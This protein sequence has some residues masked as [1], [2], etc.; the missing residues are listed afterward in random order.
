MV[1]VANYYTVVRDFKTFLSGNSSN[2]KLLRFGSLKVFV[3]I[4]LE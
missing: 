1:F 3:N 2:N 4:L